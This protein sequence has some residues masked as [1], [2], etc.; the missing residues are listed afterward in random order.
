MTNEEFLIIKNIID[1]DKNL[2]VSDL[3]SIRDYVNSKIDILNSEIYKL[4]IDDKKYNISFLKNYL[5]LTGLAL[6]NIA[7]RAFN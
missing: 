7:V 2:T 5:D 4:P 6:A 3:K 1:N